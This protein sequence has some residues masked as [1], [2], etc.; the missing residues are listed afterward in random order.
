MRR[1]RERDLQ[2]KLTIFGVLTTGIALMVACAS[3]LAL[4][5][6]LVR[7]DMIQDLTV[8]ADV[9]VTNSRSALMFDDP[10]Y[11]EETLAAFRLEQD[12]LEAA[13]FDATGRVFASYARHGRL[14]ERGRHYVDGPDGLNYED[15]SVFFKT[16][17]RYGDDARGSLYVR[18]DLAPL[19]QRFYAYGGIVIFVVLLTA[20]ITYLLSRR[21]QRLI[22][23]PIRELTTSMDRIARSKD[24]S[25]RVRKHAGD[26]IGELIDRFNDMLGRIQERDVQLKEH[27]RDL[28]EQ[29]ASRTAELSAANAELR[30]EVVERRRAQSEMLKLSSALTQ[31][32]D[33]VIVTNREG[34]IEYVNPAFEQMTGFAQDDVIGNRPSVLNS[35]E[36]EDAYF[37]R[38]WQTILSGEVFREVMV[39]RR[40]DGSTYH[41]EKTITPLKDGKGRITHFVATGKD[42]SDR[43]Q[44]QEELEYMA[45]HDSVTGLP[46]RVLLTDRLQHA[47]RRAQRQGEGVA[48]LFLDLDGFKAVNDTVGHHA[49]D[50]LLVEVAERLRGA[51]RDQDTVARLGG[52]EFAV[53]LEGHNSQSSITQVARKLIREVAVPFRFEERDLYVTVSIGVARYPRDGDRVAVL[54]RKADN[55]MY[56]AKDVGKNTFRFYTQ[57]EG[58]ADTLRQEMEQQLR[59]AVERNEFAVHYQPQVS[60]DT[61]RVTGVEALI[62]WKH[63][64]R[65]QIQPSE[66]IPVLEDSG[67]ITEVG[68]WVLRKACETAAG[69]RDQG[70]DPMRIAVNLSSMQ[71]NRGDLVGY[72]ARVLDETGLDPAYLHL[73]ITEGVLASKYEQSVTTLEKL[74]ALGVSIA[75]DD[76]GVGYSSLNYLKKFPIHTLKIDQSFVRD[77]THDADDAAIVNAIIALA[78]SLRLD[79]IAEGVETLEQ[80]FFLSRR[81][82]QEV[83]GHLLARPMTADALVGWVRANP[84]VRI[85]RPAM[86]DI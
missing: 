18:T 17:V 42:I 22:S 80:L 4:D 55:A 33:S 67:L 40:R 59:R 53:V 8:K 26:E 27:G 81:G 36:H 14:S 10:A 32:A 7:R 6:H 66:F 39:N 44:A 12:V 29:V 52:D 16:P 73:E 86:N 62:R 35:G 85:T 78:H 54:V 70:L 65:G 58:D 1:L 49:G 45:H 71:F 15:G 38:M 34:V 82:C 41:E 2:S 3:F 30:A 24:Y 25:V 64:T 19:Y 11:A 60:L 5:F 9:M 83:Q 48:V 28:E 74:N 76:F 21:M 63:P 72:V 37:E 79:V 47:L 31:A 51:V 43:I 84:R 57:T 46:N 61:G 75:V 23:D 77:V 69:W 68:D 13:V 56:R 50:R 20:F